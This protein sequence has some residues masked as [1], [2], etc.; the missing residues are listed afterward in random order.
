MSARAL[1]QHLC[2][3]L[4]YP[5]VI[6]TIFISGFGGS[7][8]YGFSLSVMTSPSAFI[9][10][11]LNQ[12][13]VE[14]YNLLLEE[15][16]VSVIWSCTISIFCIGGLVGS[17]VVTSLNT[18]FG[19]KRCLLL[20]NFVA[21]FGAVLM[22]LSQT[23]RSFEMIMV[24][25]L[26]YGISAG[27]GILAHTRYLIEC[28]PTKLRGMVGVSV[29]TFVAAGKFSGQLLGIRE[30][31]GTEK[32]WHW[33]LG[34]NG[35]TALFQLLT[36][37]F[38]PESPSF[39]LLERGDRKACETALKRLW[40]DKDFSKVVGEMLREKAAMQG[41]RD[42]SVLELFQNPTIRWQLLTI[43]ATFISLQ[44]CGI[45]AVYFYCFDVFR[46]A[47]IDEDKLPYAA[48]GTGLC[49]MLFSVV[50]FM[51]IE[52]IGKMALLFSGCVGM[53]TALILL[54]VSLFLQNHAS[55]MPYCSMVFIFIFIF[56]F[57]SGP[58]ATIVPLPGEILTQPFKSA[59]YTLGCIINWAGL[60]VL[61]M[62]FPILAENI[63]NFCFIIFPVVCILCGLHIKCNVPETKN[64]T[65][66]EITAE[67]ERMHSKASKKQSTE[68]DHGGITIHETKL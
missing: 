7:F 56:F 60:F 49:E 4:Q 41:V 5:V 13:C 22:V 1:S 68:G 39:L 25:R 63:G 64:R 9:K 19:R 45:N 14:R 55:W 59:G 29:A 10:Q 48:L 54:I 44:F 24:G 43:I 52:S 26:V 66:L 36:L 20:N 3:L 57:S 32:N 61:G 47:G 30:L 27:V 21:I 34:F 18:R 51:M 2:L 67:F 15:W 8:Q 35:F 38:L 40:G 12:T 65:I 62:G 23:A 42:H 58:A 16:Q 50:C 11:L 46:A 53:C 6:A 37:P 33:L 31:L 28:A 17:L